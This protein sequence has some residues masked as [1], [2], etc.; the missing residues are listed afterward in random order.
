MIIAMFMILLKIF[1]EKN[2]L[3]IK[4]KDIQILV[5]ICLDLQLNSLGEFWLKDRKVFYDKEL[6]KDDLFSNSVNLFRYLIKFSRRILIKEQKSL[7]W[8]KILLK[9]YL[10]SNSMNLFREQARTVQCLKI[11]YSF[12]CKIKGLSSN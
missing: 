6:L 9:D 5:W 12:Y 3:E 1:A 11:F 2:C 8:Q 7:S 10:F 4:R